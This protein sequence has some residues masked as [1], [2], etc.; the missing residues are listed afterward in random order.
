MTR[1]K[2]AIIGAG[3]SGLSA[4]WHLHRDYDVTVF[5]K[6]DYAG[7][8]SNTVDIEIDGKIMPV[9][10]GFIVFNP[11]NYPNLTALFDFLGVETVPTDM[12][13]A[14]SRGQ[15]SFEYSGGDNAGLFA[16]PLNMFR[17]R[18]WRMIS[19]ILRFYRQAEMFEEDAEAASISLGDLLQKHGFSRAFVEDHLAPMGAA[20]WSSDSRDILEYPARSFIR[21]FRNHGLVQLADR[22]QWRTVKGGSRE[23]VRLLS[24]GFENRIRL[25]RGV[26]RVVRTGGGVDISTACGSTDRF[27]QVI[28]ACHSDQALAMLADATTMEASTL[29]NMRYSKNKAVLHTER[30]WL[31]KRK[32][33]WASWNYMEAPI[34]AE[35]AG[36]AI[37]YWMNRL[38]HL[39]TETPV[40]VTLNPYRDVAAEHVLG[41]YEY[42]HPIFDQAAH[43]ARR[44]LM[45]HQGANRTWFCGAYMGDGFH[46]DGIQAGLAVAEMLSGMPRPWFRKGQNAR[47]GLPD[48][49][50]AEKAA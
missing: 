36:P 48:N 34:G 18:F 43:T 44:T 8:H 49:L 22:P 29:S 46:E 40:M 10:T 5:E 2:I 41:S 50:L 38:Q 33:A 30:A 13:F 14:V 39:L 27:D 12:S 16:Q 23:Y 15:G 9:D 6:S 17:P 32:R 20:I 25:S 1:G 47:I 45:T 42:D 4:A 11:Q 28:F 21:F 3:I 31:P 24:A 26:A 37:T 7:G 35:T 19:G